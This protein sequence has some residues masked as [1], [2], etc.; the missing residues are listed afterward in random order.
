MGKRKKTQEEFVAEVFNL[1]GDEYTILS[2]YKR[3]KDFITISHNKCGEVYQVTPDKFINDGNRCR[4]CSYLKRS[5]KQTRTHEEYIQEIFK[6]VGNEYTVL[7]NYKNA[8]KTINM[9][10]NLCGFEWNPNAQN[11]LKDGTRCPKCSGVAKINSKEFKNRILEMVGNEYTVLGEYTN[12]Q[13]KIEVKHNLCG[14]IYMVTPANFCNGKRC[15]K[16]AGNSLKTHEE[17]E[18][19][20]YELV[21]NEYSVLTKYKTA[22]FPIKMKHNKCGYEFVTIPPAFTSNGSRCPK[23]N[24]SKGET[25]ILNWL[26][27]NKIEYIAQYKIEECKYKLPLPFDFA[28]FEKNK[29]MLL[30][31][32]QGEGHYKPMRF[33]NGEKQFKLI[34]KRDKIKKD[35]CDKNNIPLLEIPYWDF[36][37]IEKI[38]EKELSFNAN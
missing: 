31:E 19:E 32:F 16:C 11:F 12:T 38:L 2:E 28:V 10:H 20:V 22:K 4:K 34:Q 8:R 23:C 1:V 27:K 3:A 21:N 15:P 18:Q 13:T 37:N 9:K 17:F 25:A 7:G 36:E 24:A 14:N 5:K 6:L 29:L 30:I 33:K 35:Y 26:E